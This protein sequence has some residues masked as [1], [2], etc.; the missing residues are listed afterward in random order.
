MPD[1]PRYQSGAIWRTRTKIKAYPEGDIPKDF[2]KNVVEIPKDEHVMLVTYM[3]S[4]NFEEHAIILWEQRTF[5]VFDIN[6]AYQ[7]N[8]DPKGFNTKDKQDDSSV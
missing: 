4:R 2:F 7:F 3:M 1:N 8:I 6:T 5:F